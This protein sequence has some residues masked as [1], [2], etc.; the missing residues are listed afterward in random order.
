M[1]YSY[2]TIMDEIKK[3][4]EITLEQES[5]FP[6][7]EE[8]FVEPALKPEPVKPKF[9]IEKMTTC[10]HGQLCSHLKSEPPARPMCSLAKIPI[11]NLNHCPELNWGNI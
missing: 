1:D 2:Q 4:S 6:S 7:S 11:F 10:L 9:K 5:S 8:S 3:R